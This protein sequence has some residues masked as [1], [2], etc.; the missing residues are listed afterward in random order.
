MKASLLNYI[1]SQVSRFRQFVGLSD[2]EDV[3]LQSRLLK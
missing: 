1:E 2:T 3:N